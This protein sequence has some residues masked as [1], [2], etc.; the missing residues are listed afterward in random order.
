[1]SSSS[2]AA[3]A[4]SAVKTK[5]Q[6]RRGARKGAS[7]HVFVDKM[8]KYNPSL[9][10]ITHMNGEAN[11]TTAFASFSLVELLLAKGNV[12]REQSGRDRWKSSDFEQALL[13]LV[14]SCDADSQALVDTWIE[15]ARDAVQA[16]KDRT[17]ASA[18]AAASA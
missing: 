3:A 1:M 13:S 7:Y 8:V 15:T 9:Q 14:E 6:R 4:N 2:P 11:A 5:K 12:F 10:A 17:G 16:H 18:G